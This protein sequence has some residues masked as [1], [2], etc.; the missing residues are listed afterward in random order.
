MW[1]I[2]IAVVALILIRFLYDT[3]KQ[4]S[5]I[6][7][8]GG[9][10]KKYSILVDNFLNGH[11]NSKI[12]QEDNTFISVGV[13]G[14]GGSQVYYIYPSYGFVSIRMEIKNNPLLGN[15]KMEWKFAEDEDQYAMIDKI[16]ADIE[17]RFL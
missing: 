10:R 5:D 2:I 15:L 3:F 6:K 1:T 9:I 14:P 7:K 12:F 16:N 11:P 17:N 8:E 13:V 4:S